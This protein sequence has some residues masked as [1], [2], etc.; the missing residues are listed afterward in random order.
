[1]TTFYTLN[2]EGQ[3]PVFISPRDRVVLL[4]SQAVGF[5]FAASYDSQGYGG[6]VRPSLYSLDTDRTENTASDGSIP[7]CVSVAAIT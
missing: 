6:G 2:L 3:V 5:H 4:H 1:M 7:A